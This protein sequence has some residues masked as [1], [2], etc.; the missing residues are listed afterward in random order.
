MSKMLW[1]FY[2][3]GIFKNNWHH[4][5]HSWVWGLQHDDMYSEKMTTIGSADKPPSYIYSIKKRE[6]EKLGWGGGI[7]LWGDFR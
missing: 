4:I 1:K 2:F 6:E 3:P 5:Y 7:S